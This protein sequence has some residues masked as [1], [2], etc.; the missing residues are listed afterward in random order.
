MEE[1]ACLTEPEVN[2][3]SQITR[4][5]LWRVAQ[6][7]YDPLGLLSICIVMWKQLYSDVES[8][9][10]ESHLVRQIQRVGEPS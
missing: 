8:A 5:V 1:N 7:Q 9:H 3:P 2:L 10:E 4:R 6:S